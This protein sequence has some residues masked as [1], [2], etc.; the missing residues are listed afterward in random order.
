MRLYYFDA[1]RLHLMQ[2]SSKGIHFS[3][4]VCVCVSSIFVYFTCIAD[5][6]KQNAI[7]LAIFIKN[8]RTCDLN[9]KLANTSQVGKRTSPLLS[10]LLSIWTDLCFSIFALFLLF[11][12]VCPLVCFMCFYCLASMHFYFTFFIFSITLSSIYIFLCV[13]RIICRI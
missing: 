3:L 7:S 4:R 13:Y 2:N 12:F 11:Y 6:H 10:R 1:F 9:G 5:T 8:R